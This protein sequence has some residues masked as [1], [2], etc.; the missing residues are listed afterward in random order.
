MLERIS[1]LY[2]NW[3]LDRQPVE[4]FLVEVLP[5]LIPCDECA[6][7]YENHL[8]DFPPD[9]DNLIKWVYDLHNIVNKEIGVEEYPVEEY[10]TKI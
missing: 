5:A 6:Y 7:N 2:H 3:R 8:V 9:F 1:V 4:A 10:L